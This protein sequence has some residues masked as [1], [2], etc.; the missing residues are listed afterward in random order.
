MTMRA[1]FRWL[2]AG[3]L[4]ALWTSACPGGDLRVPG[5][6]DMGEECFDDEECDEPGT[7]LN[8]VCSGYPCDEGDSCKNDLS[9]QQVNDQRN[10]VLE[11]ATDSDC[12][13]RQTC[14]EVA[15]STNNPTDTVEICL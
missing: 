10:C 3:M 8:G 11:C 2:A 7:C 5:G 4:L 6:K 12:I 1:T 14:I 15:R 9:C 13:G